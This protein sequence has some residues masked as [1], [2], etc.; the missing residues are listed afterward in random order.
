MR[1]LKHG[2]IFDPTDYALPVG[3]FGFSQSPQALILE[4]RIRVYF[5]TREKDITGNF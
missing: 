4:D 2:K 5:S 1:W 3:G